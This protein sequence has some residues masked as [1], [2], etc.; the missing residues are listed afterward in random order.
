[1]SLTV[2]L[3]SASLPGPLG[4]VA[5]HYWFTVSDGGRCDRWEIWQ[6][7]GA[8]GSCVGHL[9][10]NLKAPESDVGGGPA[11]L[12]A[13]WQGAEAVRLKQALE[14]AH[15]AYPFCHRYL[16]WPGPNSN[17]FVA[18]ALRRAGIDFQL[19]WNAIGRDFRWPEG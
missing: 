18:W 2:R 1:L 3:Y 5:S 15:Q 19:P 10:C 8:G 6:S 17:T 13:Q 9:H 16:P 11:Q 7:A 12:A 14:T 4:F